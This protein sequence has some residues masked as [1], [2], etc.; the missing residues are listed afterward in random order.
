MIS[1]WLADKKFGNYKVARFGLIVLFLGTSSVTIYTL[2]LG[3]LSE[4][5]SCC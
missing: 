5:Q 4:N 2:F 3:V 1:G